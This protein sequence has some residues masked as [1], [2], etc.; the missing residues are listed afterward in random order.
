MVAASLSSAAGCRTIAS[1]LHAAQMLE[2][3]LFLQ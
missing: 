1:V 2:N 3:Q